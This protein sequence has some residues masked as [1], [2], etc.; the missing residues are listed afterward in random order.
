MSIFLFSLY[1]Q[2]QVY[3]DQ[4]DIAEWFNISSEEVHCII[5]LHRG[6]QTV[7]S[8]QLLLVYAQAC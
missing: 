5:F 7:T 6:I 8:L 4:T 2:G 3:T 1:K